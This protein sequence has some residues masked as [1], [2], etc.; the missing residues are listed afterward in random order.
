MP[1]PTGVKYR[2]AVQNPRNN[3]RDADLVSSTAESSANGTPRAYNGHFTTTFRMNAAGADWAV[4][5]FTSPVA[6]LEKR[7]RIIGRYI[8]NTRPAFFVSAAFLA[9]GIQVDAHWH[10]IIKME[11]VKGVTLNLYVGSQLQAASKIIKLRDDLAALAEV[12]QAREIAHGDLQHGNII[13]SSGRP[14]LV[15]YDGIY[16]PELNGMVPD[17][18]GFKHYQ[19]PQRTRGDWG[20]HMDRFSQIALHVGLSAIAQRRDLWNEFNNSENML[21]TKS[22]FTDPAG[23]KLFS[24]LCRVDIIAGMSERFRMICARSVEAVP[25]LQDFIVQS[26]AR[27]GL[28]TGAHLGHPAIMYTGGDG[29]TYI[30]DLKEGKRHGRGTLTYTT[31][32]TYTG[33]WKEGKRHGQGTLTYSSG[34]MYTGEWKDGKRHGQGTTD[35]D[36][37][38]RTYTGGWRDGFRHGR[39]I[40]TLANGCAYTGEWVGGKRHGQGTLTYSNGRIRTGEWRYGK[41][42]L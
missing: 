21:F 22:D 14:C 35:V 2:E 26:S 8:S 31:G 39:G 42:I 30:G 13:V 10:P 17:E 36:A 7:Y 19:H 11:W 18:L 37:K 5:C 9:A 25:S 4:R 34:I 12:M 24:E 6:Q 29:A 15:D 28:V 33:E 32:R 27:R 23:S 16:L 41:F 1:L 3:F 38:G 40:E 20:P